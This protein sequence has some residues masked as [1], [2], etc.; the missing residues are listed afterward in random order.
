M[1]LSIRCTKLLIAKPGLYSV[2]VSCQNELC[3]YLIPGLSNNIAVLVRGL[4]CQILA[5]FSATFIRNNANSKEIWMF[6]RY[7][8]ILQYEMRPILPPP[9]IFF[10]HVYL[11]FKY[12][13]RRCK[14]KRDFYDNG[15]S[16]IDE[17]EPI[18]A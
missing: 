4:S 15:L 11:A 5:C 9:F 13:K 17:T 1:I 18:L 10:T 16:M 8:L 2:V 14:G 7:A 12:I 3:Y 6:Q